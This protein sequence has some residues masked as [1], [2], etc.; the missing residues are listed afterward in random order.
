MAQERG[1]CA[2]EDFS[3]PATTG[4]RPQKSWAEQQIGAYIAD[5]LE[6]APHDA[7]VFSDI[8]PV[9]CFCCPCC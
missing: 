2:G 4:E 9:R 6:I 5:L 3:Y 7:S 8:M 1:C